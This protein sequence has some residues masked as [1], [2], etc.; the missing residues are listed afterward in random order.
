LLADAT[1]EVTA[2]L[3]GPEAVDDYLRARV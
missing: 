1:G 2:R 3:V